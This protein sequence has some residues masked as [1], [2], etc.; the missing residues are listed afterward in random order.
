MSATLAGLDGTVTL[1]G[2]LALTV[3]GLLLALICAGW[4][5]AAAKA[6]RTAASKSARVL[7][8]FAQLTRDADRQVSELRRELAAIRETLAAFQVP[9]A[10]APAM[11]LGGPPLSQPA[12]VQAPAPTK[13]APATPDSEATVMFG[14]LATSPKAQDEF[15]GLPLLRLVK[16]AAE[17]V[18]REFKLPFDRSTLGRAPTNRV[19]LNEEKASRVH[20]ELR[21]ENNRFV[22]RDHD[23]TNGTRATAPV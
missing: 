9:H 7:E 10:A 5:L 8:T 22:L 3:F 13:I 18:G 11:A 2:G 4:S 20:A 23:S 6:A 12:P 19:V 17:E 21:Y 1:A 14:R 16:G 15:H